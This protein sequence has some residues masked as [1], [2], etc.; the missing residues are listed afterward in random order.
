MRHINTTYIF[1]SCTEETTDP[2]LWYVLQKKKKVQLK[3]KH[4]EISDKPR[5]GA[6]YKITGQ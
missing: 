3:Y 6:I 4:E 1:T 5:Q 2:L